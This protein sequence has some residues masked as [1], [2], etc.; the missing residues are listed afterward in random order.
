MEWVDKDKS[1]KK[2]NITVGSSKLMND[3]IGLINS[4]KDGNLDK[5]KY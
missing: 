5:D 2:W 3:W 1:E 4:V